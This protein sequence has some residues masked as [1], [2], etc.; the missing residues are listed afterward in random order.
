[1]SPTTTLLR[2]TRPHFLLLAVV[3]VLLGLSVAHYTHTTIEW[4]WLMPIL[5]GALLA[6]SSVNLLN[7]YIDFRSGL[8]T[9]TDKTPFSGG[10]GALPEHPG[11]AKAVL[12][13]GTITLLLTI[14]I[15]LYLTQQ[16]SIWLL[17]IGLLG[18]A[19]IVSYTPWLNRSPWLC[20]LAPGLGFALMVLGTQLVLAG[21]FVT[22]IWAVALVPFFLI[23]N[24]LLLNQH[25]DITAD[26]SVGRCHFPIA[27]GVNKSSAVYALFTLLA[28]L[29]II[30]LILRGDL[31]SL[32]WAT[33]LLLPVSLYA[34]FGAVRHGQYLGGQPQYLAANTIAA[35]GTPL[36]LALTLLIG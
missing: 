28:Y 10:S 20:L 4:R 11:M 12:V 19:L 23:N 25:P 27:F 22:L 9:K 30:L 2:T 14:V 32:S 35:L 16:R 8:D 21:H 3:C 6:H 33:L 18:A 13:T 15:G 31:P 1:M 5:V 29:T 34:L 36:L 17:P 26:A 7:E 24:L